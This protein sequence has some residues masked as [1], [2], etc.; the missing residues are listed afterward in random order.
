MAGRI[1]M[2]FETEYA[3][4]PMRSRSRECPAENALAEAMRTLP[5]LP[6]HGESGI[7]LSTGGRLYVDCGHHLEYSTPEC[8]DPRD[9]VTSY[10]AGDQLVMGLLAA[11]RKGRGSGVQ[12][13]KSNVCYENSEATFGAHESYSVR[14]PASVFT[15]QLMN[16][17]IS[18]IVFTGAG[19]LDPK[20]PG[21]VPCLSPRVV[22]LE[23][24]VS[25]SST[26]RRGIYHL[27]D[28]PLARNGWHRV[29]IL[30]GDAARSPRAAWLR[31]GTTA[32]VLALVDAGERLWDCPPLTAA[33]T[34]MRAYNSDL[35][36]KFRSSLTDGRSLSALDIQRIYLQAVEARRG[37]P[38]LP[39]WADEVIA[40]WRKTLEHLASGTA[41]QEARF[42]WAVKRA[43]FAQ[44]CEQR[45]FSAKKLAVWNQVLRGWQLELGSTS[46]SVLGIFSRMAE[47]P[48]ELAACPAHGASALASAGSSWDELSAFARLRAELCEID[49]RYSL[50]GP[51]GIHGQLFEQG[52]LDQSLPGG[53]NVFTPES[54]LAPPPRGRARLR[55]ECVREFSGRAGLAA[56]WTGICNS[57]TNLQLPL[58][59]PTMEERPAWIP[60]EPSTDRLRSSVSMAEVLRFEAFARLAD[61][62]RFVAAMERRP[63][64]AATWA[65]YAVLLK[66]EVND[67]RNA[68]RC[69]QH[70]LEL[71]PSEAAYHS[72]YALFLTSCMERHAEAEQHYRQ[73]LELDRRDSSILGNYASFC[74]NVHR[75]FSEAVRLYEESLRTGQSDD[76]FVLAN[77]ASLRLVQGRDGDALALLRRAELSREPVNVRAKP[78]LVFLRA[79]IELQ[80]NSP[81][82]LLLVE[83]KH[84]FAQGVAGGPWSAAT[85]EDHLRRRL[86][87]QEAAL[88]VALLCA[89]GF[90]A[91][92]ER[93]DR[94]PLWR[95]L[96]ESARDLADATTL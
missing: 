28:E 39:G 82:S 13:F 49:L 56:T 19:G 89:I 77:F 37:H 88:C 55:G 21:I 11:T 23:Q 27:R 76:S 65:S 25:G 42:D 38:A 24:D 92:R 53:S 2:G 93:L 66:N 33:V 60:Y 20:S 47:S 67:F 6:A 45:G 78:R 52:L 59:E 22:H 91:D 96:P 30:S 5:H 64:D 10:L 3:L 43:L 34:A 57:E 87:G 4:G 58:H 75:D 85:L 81:A 41:A 8:D 61:A 95:D 84:L 15:E 51:G 40:E 32:L 79:V 12:A 80:N 54:V 46:R 63:T 71:A 14:R 86:D 16:F 48:N 90:I 1:F 69:Y 62:D 68:E 94:F 31:A 50:L 70:S 9:L 72:N 83:L 18:R 36:L 26:E 29:H 17:L 74:Q 73:A 35:S 7:Y 44:H